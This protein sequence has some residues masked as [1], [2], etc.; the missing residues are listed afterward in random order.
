MDDQQEP[1]PQLPLVVGVSTRAMFNLAEE[2][3]VFRTEGVE[4]Y[5]KLQRARE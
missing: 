1:P 2:D 3:A 4:A 5:S